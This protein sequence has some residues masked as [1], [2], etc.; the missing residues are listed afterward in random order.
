MF[1]ELYRGRLSS[2]SLRLSEFALRGSGA[3]ECDSVALSEGNLACV[4]DPEMRAG[5]QITLELRRVRPDQSVWDAVSR[6]R[7]CQDVPSDACRRHATRFSA[8]LHVCNTA[9]G[10]RRESCRVSLHHTGGRVERTNVPFRANHRA[11]CRFRLDGSMELS[12]PRDR[13][14]RHQHSRSPDYRS[15]PPTPPS[16]S[17]WVVAAL[18]P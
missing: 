11:A 4:S 16:S 8:Q 3:C 1:D 14:G 17:W 18:R 5:A 2:Q 15:S 13:I 10:E 12:A 6:E 9:L 7:C